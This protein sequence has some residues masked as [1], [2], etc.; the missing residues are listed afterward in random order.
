MAFEHRLTE[1]GLL[2]RKIVRALAGSFLL[3]LFLATPALA[4]GYPPGAQTIGVSDSTMFPCDM[5]V[6]TGSNYE[7]GITVDITLD[8]VVIATATVGADGTFSV[9]V[10][11]PCDTAPGAH[12][13]GA[14]GA[15]T[16]ITVLA[17]GGVGGGGGTSGTGANLSVGILILAGL[18][19]VG[20]TAL[21]ATRRRV[22]VAQ[23]RPVAE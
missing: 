8:G 4:Q 11:I 20:V 9:S 6:V 22:K 12:V 18:L 13:L 7:P 14:G 3:T 16:Q 17:A 2:M 5:I 23:P 21:V 15:N 1:K 19:V 10:Q